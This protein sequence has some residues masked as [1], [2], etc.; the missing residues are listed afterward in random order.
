M[1]R[2]RHVVMRKHSPILPIKPL[3]GVGISKHLKTS[4]WLSHMLN[5]AFSQFW[6][7]F[8][9]TWSSD[10]DDFLE[11]ILQILI[12]FQPL[13]WKNVGMEIYS[14]CADFDHRI[15][16]ILMDTYCSFLLSGIFWWQCIAVYH[17]QEYFDG[18]IAV[19]DQKYF[20]DNIEV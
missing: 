5:M 16:N 18:N 12:I 13:L 7:Q 15:K 1:L 10:F 17:Y 14:K 2:D 9:I 11:N 19:Y 4:S 6:S 3:Q 8:A 20:N